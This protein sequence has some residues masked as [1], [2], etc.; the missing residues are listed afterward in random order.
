MHLGRARKGKGEKSMCVQS[1]IPRPAYR[2]G[3]IL[4]MVNRGHVRPASTELTGEEK[5][6]SLTVPRCHRCSSAAAASRS[7]STVRASARGLEAA[8]R[9][10]TQGAGVLG[11]KPIL[12]SNTLGG[13]G[14][15]NAWP[16]GV[17]MCV[18]DGSGLPRR[19]PASGRSTG[20]RGDRSAGA[21]PSVCA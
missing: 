4:C 13:G 19:T 11:R 12:A 15:W 18:D 1:M 5:E 9:G 3:G 7:C 6:V 17:A 2:P 21:E 14:S 8:E 20:T 16:C 10:P